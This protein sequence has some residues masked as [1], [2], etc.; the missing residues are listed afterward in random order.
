MQINHSTITI[1]DFIF[2]K[3]GIQSNLIV[4]AIDWIYKSS[5]NRLSAIV[6]LLPQLV[7]NHYRG[8]GMS[9]IKINC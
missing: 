1:I 5:R 9:L 8:R 6:K 4:A 7:E 3:A 2:L